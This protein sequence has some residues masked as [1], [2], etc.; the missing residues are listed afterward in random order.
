MMMMMGSSFDLTEYNSVGLS[1]RYVVW[2]GVLSWCL[3]FVLVFVSFCFMAFLLIYIISYSLLHT[4]TYVYFD[5][6]FL[7]SPPLCLYGR[8]NSSQSLSDKLKLK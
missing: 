3:S 8:T 7:F 4:C 6:W 5:F 2:C 1:L